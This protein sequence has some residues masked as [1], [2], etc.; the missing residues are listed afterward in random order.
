MDTNQL[1]ASLIDK[2]VI[3]QLKFAHE[4]VI[5]DKLEKVKRLHDLKWAA[6]LGNGYHGKVNILF[7]TEDGDVKR[8][9]TTVWAYDQDFVTLKSG[10]S[11]PIRCILSIEHI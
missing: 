4:D 9:E 6:V 8:V 10:T 7:Q 2:E 5:T 1:H 3:P 11:M